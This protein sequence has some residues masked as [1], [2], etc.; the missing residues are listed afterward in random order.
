MKCM[1]AQTRP[2]FILSSERVL[3]GMEFEP[4]LTPREKSP[5]PKMSPEED[6]TLDAVDSE[7]KHYQLSY[8]GPVALFKTVANVTVVAVFTNGLCSSFVVILII[9]TVV[10]VVVVVVVIVE[11]EEGKSHVEFVMSGES[12]FVMQNRA[13]NLAG[14]PGTC[15]FVPSQSNGT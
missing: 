2:R 10:V 3:V 1:Y 11:E 9:I 7:P 15:P 12:A 13:K 6:R 5:L 4:M 14:L 8:S